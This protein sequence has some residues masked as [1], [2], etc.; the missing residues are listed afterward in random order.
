M[1]GV[2]RYADDVITIDEG[3][4]RS[5]AGRLDLAGTLPVTWSLANLKPDLVHG[6]PYDLRMTGRS[7]PA[8]ALAAFVPLFESITGTAE[9]EL[10]LTGV[11]DSAYFVGEF[12]LADARIEIPGFVDPLVDGQATGRFD[13]RGLE[14]IG[15]RLGDGRGGRIAGR[16]RVE[17]ANLRATDWRIDVDVRDARYRGE[18]NGIDAVGSG[19]LA[20][21]AVPRPDG[22]PQP[23]FTGAFEVESAAMDERVLAPPPGITALPEMPAGVNAPAPTAEEIAEAEAAAR[24]AAADAPPPLWAEIDFEADNNLWLRTPE[25]QVELAGAV[26]LHATPEYVGLTGDL[27]T[28]QGTYSVLNTTFNVER[29]EVRFFDASDP[30]ATSLDAEA[31][32]SV[33]DEEVTALVTGT[34]AVPV[35]QLSTESGMTEREIFEL[36]ALR[37]KPE[38]GT[39]GEE[40]AGMV[41]SDLV[42]SWGAVLASRFG[43]ELGREVGLDTFDVEQGQTATHI[44]LGKSIGSNLFLRYRQEVANTEDLTTS[45][46]YRERLETPERQLLLEYRL[47]RIFQLQGETGTIEGDGYLNVDLKA[48]W[49]Y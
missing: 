31:T 46:T 8:R 21:E 34:L 6:S 40:E 11:P 24:A 35:I 22:A 19:R 5:G 9:A 16:G 37:Q 26:T 44:G 47:S 2:G 32:T 48:E 25:Q 1:V 38:A 18:I 10:T 27:R 43:R 28:L 29:A 42:A 45:D 7:F 49:G 13:E 39:V 33:L 3:W 4:V 12:S 20:I 36:L 23:R 15:A 41:S 14:I 17:L 30:G